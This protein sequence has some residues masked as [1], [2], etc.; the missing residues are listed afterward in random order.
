MGRF[1]NPRYAP[2]FLERRLSPSDLTGTGTVLVGTVSCLDGTTPLE[3]TP[4]GDGEPPD[5]L[6]IIPVGPSEP[7]A[8]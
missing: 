1:R 8:A 3:P 6:P 5:I 4:D 7:A 2:E